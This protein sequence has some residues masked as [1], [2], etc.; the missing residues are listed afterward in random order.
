[1]RITALF[2]AFFVAVVAAAPS[3]VAPSDFSIEKRGMD[4]CDC[5]ES[6]CR[7]PACCANGTC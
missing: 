2:I 4:Q 3:P 5:D 6:S 1:M 7:G